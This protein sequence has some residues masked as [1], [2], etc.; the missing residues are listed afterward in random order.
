MP[1]SAN[2]SPAPSSTLTVPSSQIARLPAATAPGWSAS[3]VVI[4]EQLDGDRELN[5]DP[6]KGPVRAP[7][8]SWGPYLWANGT[9]R[10]SDGFSY[11]EADFGPAGTTETQGPTYGTDSSSPANAEDVSALIFIWAT[12][13]A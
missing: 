7:W 4:K 1:W 2:G 9:A 5:F 12:G 10:R 8:L 6:E 11:E 13:P 3:K